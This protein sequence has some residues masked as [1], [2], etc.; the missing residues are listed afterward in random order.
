DAP[1]QGGLIALL[2]L[3]LAI[4]SYQDWYGWYKKQAPIGDRHNPRRYKSNPD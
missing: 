2:L 3:W 1:Q 4:R